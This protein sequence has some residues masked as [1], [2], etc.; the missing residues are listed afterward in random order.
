M[1][2]SWKL[3]EC[4]FQENGMNV[5]TCCAERSRFLTGCWSK[6]WS[7]E[8]MGTN[9]GLEG[10]WCC[11]NECL[12]VLVCEYWMPQEASTCFFVNKIKFSW[13]LP[14]DFQNYGYL[15]IIYRWNRG[16][17]YWRIYLKLILNKYTKIDEREL[18]EL[19]F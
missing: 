2:S 7:L 13:I 17:C 19:F 5:T 15:T 18:I 6:A 11:W 8:S 14:L 1:Q 3:H 16:C 4:H 9:R 10:C 12:F